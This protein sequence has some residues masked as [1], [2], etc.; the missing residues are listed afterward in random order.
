MLYEF[1][2]VRGGEYELKQD[3]KVMIEM[4]CIEFCYPG[5]LEGEEDWT[6]ICSKGGGIFTVNMPYNSVIEIWRTCIEPIN[7]NQ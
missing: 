1:D 3:C 5:V 6:V 7:I 4:S 2:M